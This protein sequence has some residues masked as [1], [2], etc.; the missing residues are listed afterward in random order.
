MLYYNLMDKILGL[1]YLK[2]VQVFN[3]K[4]NN[5]NSIKSMYQLLKILIIVY[6]Y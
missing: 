4:I 6:M 5:L 1:I 3:N 2:I